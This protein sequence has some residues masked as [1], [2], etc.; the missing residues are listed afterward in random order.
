L[1]LAVALGEA[2]R[3]Y[4]LGQGPFLA[5]VGGKL[6]AEGLGYPHPMTSKA[7]LAR[8]LAERLP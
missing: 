8:F 2:G 4:V 1:R 3:P 6:K 5:L 7:L